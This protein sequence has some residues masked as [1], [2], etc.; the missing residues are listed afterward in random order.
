MLG[1]LFQKTANTITGMDKGHEDIQLPR[2]I[3]LKIVGSSAEVLVTDRGQGHQQ[4]SALDT[5][6]RNSQEAL[7]I[8]V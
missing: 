7:E 4:A 2:S 5:L 8:S 1:A 6:G 3:S